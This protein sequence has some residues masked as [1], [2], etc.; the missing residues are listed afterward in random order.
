MHGT[1]SVDSG[2]SHAIQKDRFAALELDLL[3]ASDVKLL[4]TVEKVTSEGHSTKNVYHL[5]S[6]ALK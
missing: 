2:N 1:K 4:L 5:S 3:A 6:Q